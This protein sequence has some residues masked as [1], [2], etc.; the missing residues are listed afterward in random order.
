MTKRR[1]D[2]AEALADVAFP[3]DQE[4]VWRYTPIGDLDIER[5]GPTSDTS[6]KDSTI[7][8]VLSDRVG[9][10]EVRNGWVTREELDDSLRQRGLFVGRLVDHPD[11]GTILGSVAGEST[12]YFSVL[13]DAFMGDA[14]LI[15]V[16]AG[17]VVEKPIVVG[18]RVRGD[19]SAVFPRLI[20]RMGA[21]SQASVVQHQSAG[22]GEVFAAPL[23]ELDVGPAAR[24]EFLNIQVMTASATQL[25]SLIARAGQ[26]A[27]VTVGAA[28][29]G[30][31]YSRLRLDCRLEGSGS[32]GNLLAMYYGE[33]GQTLDFRTLQDHAAPHTTSNLLFKGALAGD[34]RSIYTGMIRVRPEANGT[35]AFQTNRN[36]KLSEQAWAESVPNLE[37][38]NSDVRC[39]HASTVSPIDEEQLFYLES[40]G[41]PSETAER[42]IVRG[43][44]ADVLD[45]LPV[46]DGHPVIDEVVVSKQDR[47]QAALK[48]VDA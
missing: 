21:D 11:A 36:I 14:V 23:T 29:L 40:R 10:V 43:F 12:D 9:L 17:L 25:G 7:F 30:G 47:H 38:E 27:T 4:E 20:V 48:S 31:G 45:Q 19:G 26:D 32:T 42:L 41:V 46:G 37:I 3:S 13:S 22:V 35:N 15:D 6:G 5:F 2:A 28:G 34:A 8:D 1:N 44:F 39:S 33:S 16:P 24:L 18:E